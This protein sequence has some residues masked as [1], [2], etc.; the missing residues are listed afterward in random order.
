[1]EVNTVQ[2]ESDCSHFG[3][4]RYILWSKWV[5]NKEQYDGYLPIVIPVVVYHGAAKWQ[6]ST[7]FSDIFRLP[8]EYFRLF[9]PKLDHNLHDVLRT[10]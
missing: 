3:A 1:M 10:A 5:K 2:R 6:Y 4:E 8:S 7:E 9:T